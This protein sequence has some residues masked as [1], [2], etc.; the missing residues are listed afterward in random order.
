MTEFRGTVK[1]MNLINNVTYQELFDEGTEKINRVILE[2]KTDKNQPIVRIL[3]DNGVELANYYLPT[4]AYLQVTNGQRVNSGDALVKMPRAASKTKDI[5]TGGLPRIAELFEARLPKDPAIM[6][7]IDGE[8][9]VGGIHRGMKTISIVSGDQT[10]DYSVPRG[11]QLKVSDGDRVQ[12]GELLTTGEPVLQDILR[13][14]GPDSVQR[15]LVDQIQ[16]I[17]RSHGI[18][19]NDRHIEV[20]VRQMM[21]KVRITESGDSDFLVGDR[22]DRLKF[23]QVNEL[24]RAEGRRVAAAKPLMM[25][26]TMASLDTES[27]ISAASFQETTRILTEAAISG[28]EDFLYGL[29]ENIIIGKLIP[30]GTGIK[31]FQEKYIGKD[32]TQLEREAERLEKGFKGA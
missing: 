22:I 15:Y 3:D 32:L 10:Y 12:A 5:T 30:A 2:A 28:Q 19:T 16:E 21:R 7:D 23:R 25:G 8:V 27:M 13:I 26:I 29:K 18:D 24:I 1:L 17:Y 4:G 9:V 11:K 6:A 14:K 20:I 31:S